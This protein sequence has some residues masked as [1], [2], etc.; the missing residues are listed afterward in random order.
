MSDLLAAIQTATDADLK[1]V[2]SR[3]DELKAEADSLAVVRRALMAR[4]GRKETKAAAAK[5]NGHSRNGP[6]SAAE[7]HDLLGLLGAEG[8]MAAEVIAGR[9]G[10]TENRV[11]TI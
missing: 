4:L 7:R 8:A 3:I 1:A 10:T 11:A 5:T 6:P 2:E 9:M